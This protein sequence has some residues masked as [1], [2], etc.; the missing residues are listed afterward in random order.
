MPFFRSLALHIEWLFVRMLH[1]SLE[2]RLG[3]KGSTVL[4]LLCPPLG[5]I[6][7]LDSVWCLEQAG[8]LKWNG[9]VRKGTHSQ[10]INC[11]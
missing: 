5:S 2:G 8:A 9:Q 10:R 6:R 3:N 4:Y 7:L 1:G 11:S